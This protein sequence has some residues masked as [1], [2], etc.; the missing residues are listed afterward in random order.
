MASVSKESLRVLHQ[1]RVQ[2]GLHHDH[3][4]NEIIALLGN[5][6]GALERFL[7]SDAEMTQREIDGLAQLFKDSSSLIQN[8]SI[9][10]DPKEHNRDEDSIKLCFHDVDTILFSFFG[11][12]EASR[13]IKA[14]NSKYIWIFLITVLFIQIALA[15]SGSPIAGG[16]GAFSCILYSIYILLWIMYSN[17]CALKMVMKSFQTLFKLLY[18]VQF[19]C[20]RTA[21]GYIR[22]DWPF[23]GYCS[24]AMFFGTFL[25]FVL[26]FD[27]MNIRQTHKVLMSCGAAGWFSWTVLDYRDCVYFPNDCSYHDAATVVIPDY[28]GFGEITVSLIDTAAKSGTVLC[29]FLVKQA[30]QSIFRPD[31][32]TVINKKPLI[33]FADQ[34][35]GSPSRLNWSI[36]AWRIA[37]ICYHVL[38]ICTIFGLEPYREFTNGDALSSKTHLFIT[39]L[40]GYYVLA[41]SILVVILL[42]FLCNKSLSV[43][44]AMVAVLIWMVIYG[45]AVF[46]LDKKP[47]FIIFGFMDFGLLDMYCRLLSNR[48]ASEYKANV[49]LKEALLSDK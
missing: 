10:A 15:M 20:V 16:F 1:Q 6:D 39:A 38:G 22:A 7:K 4:Q 45:I 3:L 17:K 14:I 28:F 40:I 35:P 37:L 12:H 42:F 27:A 30:I 13:I 8:T 25:Y 47:I 46:F 34:S 48:N 36:K 32:A 21:I 2:R 33:T 23:Y 18:L 19:L 31:Q 11:Q 5:I 9:H 44:A 24:S 49:E 41:G 26:I 29:I 43:R